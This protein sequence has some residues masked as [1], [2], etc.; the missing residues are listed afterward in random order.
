M[1]IVAITRN[2]R[3][4]MASD[5][6][7]MG[8]IGSEAGEVMIFE[9]GGS[10]VFQPMAG[11]LVGGFSTVGT[12]FFQAVADMQWPTL[13]GSP[14][15]WLRRTIV[16]EIFAHL[17]GKGFELRHPRDGYRLV[18]QMMVGTAD[19]LFMVTIEGG[20]EPSAECWNVIGRGSVAVEGF[21]A[22]A[23]IAG[24]FDAMSSKEL[25]RAA[26]GAAARTAVGVAHSVH[27]I[28]MRE[29]GALVKNNREP[30]FAPW[31]RGAGNVINSRAAS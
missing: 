19:G 8:R 25:C 23:R 14:L 3:V 10:K 13:E 12:G 6:G 31:V 15:E 18:P 22:G 26:L 1:A 27:V 5:T 16:P 4:T 29:D 30:L 11:V 7:G 2:G 17:K 21:L 20:V 28:E 9:Q 24:I